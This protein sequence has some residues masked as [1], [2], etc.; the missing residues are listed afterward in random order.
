MLNEGIIR[1]DSAALVK[2]EMVRQLR[3][4]GETTPELW[5]R[6]TFTA[7]TGST[8]DEIDWEVEDNKAGYYL[9]LKGFDALIQ[10]LVD[11]GYAVCE[12]VEGTDERTIRPGDEIDEGTGWSELV[13]PPR[14]SK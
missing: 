2:S 5:E 6:A 8:R 1:S 12:P 10:E 3:N 7:L 11:D 4:L 13:Y 9:W 14:P